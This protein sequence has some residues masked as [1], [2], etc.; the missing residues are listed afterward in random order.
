MAKKENT[1]AVAPALLTVRVLIAGSDEPVKGLFIAFKL[2][3]ANALTK[4]AKVARVMDVDHQKDFKDKRYQRLQEQY[5]AQQAETVDDPS[6]QFVLG[7]RDRPVDAWRAIQLLIDIQFTD[8]S[9]DDPL[10]II[11]VKNDKIRPNG[12][13]FRFTAQDA[14]ADRVEGAEHDPFRGLIGQQTFDALCH[15]F[16]GLVRKGDRQDLP[17]SNP[18]HRDEIGDPLGEHTRLPGPRTRHL[19]A[20]RVG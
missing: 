8:H 4:A 15:F 14:R 17:R 13:I 19:T 11:C 16:G 1:L 2:A 5:K 18:F 3:A 7:T 10:L 9:L 20:S 6:D 12:Q